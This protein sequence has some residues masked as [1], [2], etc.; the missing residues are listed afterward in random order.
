MSDYD[1]Y[2]AHNFDMASEAEQEVEDRWR[3]EQ[4]VAW[5]MHQQEVYDIGRDGSPRV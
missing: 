5:H 4:D 3:Y 1:D 2:E